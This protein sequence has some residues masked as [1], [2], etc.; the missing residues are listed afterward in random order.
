MPLEYFTGLLYP[1]MLR[2][3]VRLLSVTFVDWCFG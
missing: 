2:L 1:A 3:Y